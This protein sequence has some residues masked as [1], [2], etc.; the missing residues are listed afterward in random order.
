MKSIDSGCHD[1]KYWC[2]FFYTEFWQVQGTKDVKRLGVIGTEMIAWRRLPNES[3][4][5]VVYMLKSIGP[6]S[7]TDKV[8]HYFEA[9]K[10]NCVDQ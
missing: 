5:R 4:N 7:E 9:F 8:I 3:A 1:L 10:S 2:S 6:S